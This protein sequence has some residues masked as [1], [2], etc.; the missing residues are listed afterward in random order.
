MRYF[1]NSDL[2]K[3]A[4]QEIGDGTQK[5][6]AKRKGVSVP[7]LCD[8]LNGRIEA[9]PMILRALGFHVRPFYKRVEK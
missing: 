4:R 2:V 5:E 9:G 3:L 1:C 7:Y 6:W 8:F